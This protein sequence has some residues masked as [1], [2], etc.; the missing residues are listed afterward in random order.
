MM[1][2][3]RTLAILV[4]TGAVLAGCASTRSIAEIQHFPGRF[5]DDDVTIRGVV[6]SS[7]SVPLVPV[8]V[9]RVDDG[10]GQMTVIATEGRVPS[11]G[12]RVNVRGRISEFGSFG[13]R[14]VGLHMRQEDLDY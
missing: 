12:A 7:W 14:T 4:L 5:D 13:G 1:R 10:S 9:Y 3:T 8:Q 11:R 2:V 6:T